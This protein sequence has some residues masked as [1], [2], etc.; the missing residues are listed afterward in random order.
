MHYNPFI[1][2]TLVMNSYSVAT[3][4][5]PQLLVS[6]ITHTAQDFLR[7]LGHHWFSLHTSTCF[8]KCVFKLSGKLTRVS[9]ENILFHSEPQN[10]WQ[11]A[12]L[13]A[14]RTL[15]F[16]QDWNGQCVLLAGISVIPHSQSQPGNNRLM[17][18]HSS[19]G[20]AENLSTKSLMLSCISSAVVVYGVSPLSTRNLTRFPRSLALHLCLFLTTANLIILFCSSQMSKSIVLRIWFRT[21]SSESR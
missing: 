8:A 15:S 19:N 9:L 21:A 11:V 13:E 3:A 16:P 6:P 17:P 10:I 18:L 2:I 7:I 20:L 12:Q 1:A 4:S 5:T 14:N